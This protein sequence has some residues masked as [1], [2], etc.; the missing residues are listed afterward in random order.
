[1]KPLDDEELR[2][3]LAQWETPPA[4]TRL[5]RRVLSSSP[6]R[7]VG[8]PRYLRIRTSVAAISLAALLMLAYW[9]GAKR[10]PSPPASTGL[11]SFQPA[12][13]PNLRIVRI[14]ENEQD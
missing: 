2:Q 1:M 6:R 13:N 14:T 4:P 12:K 10:S 3:L 7:R 11:A 5:R 8:I 9:A